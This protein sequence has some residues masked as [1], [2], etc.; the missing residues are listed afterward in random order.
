MVIV[1]VSKVIDLG[2]GKPMNLP[3]F[4][5]NCFSRPPLAPRRAIGVVS[6]FAISLPS[7]I[8]SNS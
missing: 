6:F 3:F 1:W 8:S 7:V 4:C 2:G 5:R